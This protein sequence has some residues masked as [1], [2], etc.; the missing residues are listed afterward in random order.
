MPHAVYDT[1]PEDARHVNVPP[2]DHEVE[3][4]NNKLKGKK[5]GETTDATTFAKSDLPSVQRIISYNCAYTLEYC[6]DRFNI[7]LAEDGTVLGVNRG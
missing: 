1:D 2:V 5:L 3:E 4:W 6:R 7:Y